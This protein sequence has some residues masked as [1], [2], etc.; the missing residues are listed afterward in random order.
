MKLAWAKLAPLSLLLLSAPAWAQDAEPT[1]WTFGVIL[2]MLALG[3]G[4]SAAV[5]GLW[6]GRDKSRPVTFALAMT[7]LISSAVCVGMTQSYLDSVDNIKAE[8]DLDRMMGMV[9]EIAIAS[10]DEELAAIIAAEGG[11]Q[12]KIEKPEPAPEPEPEP[13][14][15][16][17]EEEA[18]Q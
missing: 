4:G 10:G 6:I 1:P 12:L 13:E 2:S 14:E 15:E 8:A 11:P 16:A 5:L 7:I 9:G 17:V 18:G 3:V